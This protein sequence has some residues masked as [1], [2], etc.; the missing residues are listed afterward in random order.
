MVEGRRETSRTVCP[1]WLQSAALARAV[2]VQTLV[3]R[4]VG[5]E[6]HALVD[7]WQGFETPRFSGFLELVWTPRFSGFLAL[8]RVGS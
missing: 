5:T 4:Y 2:L 1:D 7:F 3:G 6:H 8:S